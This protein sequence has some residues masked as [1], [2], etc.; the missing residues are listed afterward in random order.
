MAESGTTVTTVQSPPFSNSPIPTAS[1]RSPRRED[2]SGTER[3]FGFSQFL[4]QPI[5]TTNP[6]MP[7]RQTRNDDRTLEHSVESNAGT[8]PPPALAGS[9]QRRDATQ[10]SSRSKKR[11]R[12]RAATVENQRSPKNRL[13]P[14]SPTLPSMLWS[15]NAGN[16]SLL[17]MFDGDESDAEEGSLF[18]ARKAKAASPSDIAGNECGNKKSGNENIDNGIDHQPQPSLFDVNVGLDE[19]FSD[20]D[21]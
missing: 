10:M 9:Q 2:G 15:S 17:E 4:S 8:P 11:R 1:A 21:E 5:T 14:K 20:D 3:T 19:L 18:A 7:P 12:K 13:S 16:S 6:K